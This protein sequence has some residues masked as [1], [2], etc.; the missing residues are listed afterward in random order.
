[1][2]EEWIARSTP[3]SFLDSFFVIVLLLVLEFLLSNW[4]D[5]DHEQEHEHE[6]DYDY[7]CGTEVTLSTFAYISR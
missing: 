7:D 4:S 6:H 5:C 3:F 1:M 2:W